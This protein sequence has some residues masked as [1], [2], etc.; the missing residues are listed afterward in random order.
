MRSM[1]EVRPPEVQKSGSGGRWSLCVPYPQKRTAAASA[2]RTT[3]TMRSIM[4]PVSVIGLASCVVAGQQGPTVHV[5]S[6]PL[7]I[8]GRSLSIR[9]EVRELTP[10]SVNLVVYLVAHT[11]IP[12]V[13]VDVISANALLRVSPAGC[14]LRPLEPPAVSHTDGPPYPL[15]A[16]PLCSFV[17]EASRDATY[18]LRLRVRNGSG[19]DLVK[20][21]ETAVVI[22]GGS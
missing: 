1:P 8:Q 5:S 22:H 17:L 21:I 15:P 7:S 14:V 11:T 13:S 12:Q 9:A 10:R 4:I 19:T 2:T 16:A 18:P 3:S 20:P 6:L